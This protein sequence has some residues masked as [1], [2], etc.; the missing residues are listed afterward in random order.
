[1][2]YPIAWR[3]KITHDIRMSKTWLRTWLAWMGTPLA[4]VASQFQFFEPVQVPHAVQVAAHRGAAGQ[5][6]QNTRPALARCIEDGFEWAE[7]D[8]QLTRDGRHVL[9]HDDRLDLL[10]APGK[11]VGDLALEDLRKLEAGAWFAP[12]FHG[13][14]ILTL[15][16][17]LKQARGKLNLYLDC[18]KVDWDALGREIQEMGMQQQVVVFGP[19]EGLSRLRSRN[20]SRIAV[21]AKWHPADGFSSW[22]DS[23]QPDAVEI[24]TPE[25]TPAIVES[26]HRLGIKVQAK[27]L[28]DWDQPAWWDR[29]IQDRVDWIQTDLPEEIA[30]RNFL[31]NTPR[32]PALVSLHR[33]ANRYAPENTLP[34]FAKAGRLGADFIEIDVRT[35]RDGAYFLLHD[36]KLD[37]TTNGKGSIREKTALEVSRLDAGG[38]FGPR[39]TGL[40][41]PT[42]DE[43]LATLPPGMQ[44]YCDAKEIAPEALA[45]SLERRG[46]IERT[47]VYQ[48]ADYLLRLKRINPRLRLLPPLGQRSE[49]DALAARLQPY[50]VDADWDNLSQEL[51]E[52]CHALGIKVFSD[53]L[54]RNE[55]IARYLQALDWGIDLIQT[56]CPLRV[57]RAMELRAL[58]QPPQ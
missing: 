5:A 37:R 53:A 35:T 1:V 45:A 18:K 42:L 14:R 57:Y 6:P 8:V 36:G 29:L 3:G 55:K 54:G 33:G 26:F 46:L 23:L 11:A 24:D 30:A 25:V 50:A 22:L 17:A 20:G 28:G 58:K 40:R 2:A 31:R 9:W 34:A 38:W 56:D 19:P 52:R 44:L 13:E 41:L 21:M 27:A 10:Q 49:L 43:M 4:V 39:F 12:R 32:R 47:V 48:S 15:Q 7:V 16:E 51:I